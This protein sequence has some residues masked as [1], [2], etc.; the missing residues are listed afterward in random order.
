MPA[1]QQ[2]A[3]NATNVVPSLTVDDIGKSLAFYEVLGFIVKDRWDENGTLMYAMLQSGKLQ[4]GLNQDD[5]KKGRERQKG[6]G[7]RLHIETAQ[8]LDEIAARV[9]AAGI[10]LD[11]EPFD[12]PWKTR[13]FELTDPSGFKLTVSTE[14]PR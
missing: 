13:Q 4:I 6:L 12:T 14:W 2:S 7:T 9:K 5:W 1:T 10:R 3:L 11:A 8:N